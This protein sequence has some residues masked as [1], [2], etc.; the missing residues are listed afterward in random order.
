MGEYYGD[1]ARSS[2]LTLRIDAETKKQLDD[3]AKTTRRRRS[4]VATEAIRNYLEV[5]A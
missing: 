3:L 2:V 4:L 5:S 1:M